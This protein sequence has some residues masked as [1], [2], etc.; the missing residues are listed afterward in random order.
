VKYKPDLKN[1]Y[2]VW[3]CLYNLRIG[4]ICDC[5]LELY[6]KVLQ[7]FNHRKKDEGNKMKIKVI[8]LLLALGAVLLS[9][10]VGNQ[11][12]SPEKN[13]TPTETV[14]PIE[15]A[16]PVEIMTPEVNAT[17]AVTST[18]EGNVTPATGVIPTPGLRNTPY[19]IRLANFK[20]SPSSLEI[21][22]GETVAWMNLQE[23]PNRSFTLVSQEGLF[24]KTNLV[25]KRSFTYTFNETGNY[26]FT[27]VGQP[28]MNVSV[29]V[30]S[31]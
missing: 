4:Y 6:S 7:K 9:G 10:C 2:L 29:G 12:P 18:P 31:P 22:K 28:K 13:A 24:E 14:T 19:L 15:T 26:N 30:A 8:V 25:Y 17:P 1:P 23:N 11:Q 16:T 21:K 27:V 5:F 20:A 3:K